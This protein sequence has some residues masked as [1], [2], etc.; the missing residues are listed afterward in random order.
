MLVMGALALAVI[1]AFADPLFVHRNFF[2]RDMGPY[3]LPIEAEIHR[4]WA[5]GHLPLWWGEVSGGRPLLPNPNAGVFYPL[6]LIGALLPFLLYF[7]LFPVVH[8]ILIA[9][10]MYFLARRLG[11]SREASAAAGLLLAFSGP[12]MGEV[13]LV[14]LLPGLAMLVWSWWAVAGIG[15]KP[16]HRRAG[17]LG[18]ILALGLLN[19]DPFALLLTE[20]LCVLWIVF[21]VASG[22][23]LS[24]FIRWAEANILAVLLAAVQLVPTL[25]YVGETD[26]ALGGLKLG[27][28][29]DW[30]L[31]PIRL[32]EWFVPFPFGRTV[33]GIPSQVWG[34]RFLDSRP[35]GFF[36]TLFMG[37]L[38][39]IGL[40]EALRRRRPHH[41]MVFALI[42][43]SVALASAPL[44]VPARLA[45]V[46]AIVPLRFPEKFMIGAVVA[47]ALF[48]AQEWDEIVRLRR[49]PRWPIGV[50]AG[51]ALLA[52][53]L[54]V[55]G[56]RV[57]PALLAFT[58]GTLESL[59]ALKVRLP[60]VA[61]EGAMHWFAGFILLA[62]L[63]RFGNR[64][65]LAGVLILPLA[66][67]LLCATR[68]LAHASRSEFLVRKPPVP[69]ALDR[70]DPDRKMCLINFCDYLSESRMARAFVSRLG[71]DRS[72]WLTT[73]IILDAYWGRPLVFNMDPDM[74]DLYRMGA[75]RRL[76]FWHLIRDPRQHDRLAPF[77]AGISGGYVLRYRD[78]PPLP[79]S[80]PAAEIGALVIDRVRSAVPRVRLADRWVEVPDG[81]EAW[82]RI[83]SGV[84]APDV[85][86]VESGRS[87]SGNSGPSSLRIERRGE[88]RLEIDAQA[89]R[90]TWL[91]VTR[92]F[93]PWRDVEVDGF[94]VPCVPERF[95]FSAVR[96]PAGHHHVSWRERVPGGAAGAGLSV[97]GVLL[98]LFEWRQP[99]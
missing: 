81:S 35:A 12:V 19:V 75:L 76:F 97:A 40:I 67:L 82:R 23:R 30:S 15:E 16:S 64:K 94:P 1:C 61:L 9:W 72:A 51:F 68:Q 49:V 57:A 36:P 78:Y 89:P 21:E 26:R 13:L 29:L 46:P 70:M 71:V 8:L 83:A 27:E 11:H 95:A 53:A 58:Q 33:S 98:L 62:L 54:A 5:S 56:A 25:L 47:M 91:V 48:A 73:T 55:V 2:A 80:T 59:P 24:S 34:G 74:S 44:L 14:I 84:D 4:S 69:S 50:A 45:M 37:V 20:I 41:R 3:F 39:A 7:K 92:Q 86:I 43:V 88:S 60:W 66:A 10:G 77:L 22:D 38:A 42:L 65:W 28:T 63:A 85:A 6:R 52:G 31:Y 87:A 32:I 79:G 96:F 17:V 93:W 99:A 18:I 90:S